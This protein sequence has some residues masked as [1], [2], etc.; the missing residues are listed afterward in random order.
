MA[1]GR[2]ADDYHVYAIEWTPQ[3]VDFLVEG[4]SYHTVTPASLPAGRGGS[5]DHPFP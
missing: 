5:H 1:A 4:N 3:R 2:F